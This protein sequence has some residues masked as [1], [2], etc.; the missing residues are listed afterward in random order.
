[1][2]DLSP[3]GETPHAGSLTTRY[4]RR[5]SGTPFSSLGPASAATRAPMCTAGH[6]PTGRSLPQPLKP[7]R[8]RPCP[9]TERMTRP[10]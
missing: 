3:V 9:L 6:P 8:F 10:D 7:G 4:K 2:R 1:M 5:R